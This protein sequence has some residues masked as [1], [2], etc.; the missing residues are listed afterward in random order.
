VLEPDIVY[1]LADCVSDTEEIGPLELS[2][3]LIS[4]S[5]DVGELFG[6]KLPQLVNFYTCA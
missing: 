5:E 3:G 4:T 2:D 6:E 1:F